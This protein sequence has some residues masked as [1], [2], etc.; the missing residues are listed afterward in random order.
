MCIY[1]YIN[2][3]IYMFIMIRNINVHVSIYIYI[4]IYIYKPC[5]SSTNVKMY[6]LKANSYISY[7]YHEVDYYISQMPFCFDEGKKL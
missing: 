2:M 6:L 1:I 5:M 3:Y 7:H 4:Y